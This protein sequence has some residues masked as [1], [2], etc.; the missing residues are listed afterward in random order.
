MGPRHFPKLAVLLLASVAACAGAETRPSVV[1]A[2][3]RAKVASGSTNDGILSHF[4]SDAFQGLTQDQLSE[5]LR[6]Y[7]EWIED[8]N[9]LVERVEG[10]EGCVVFPKPYR[11]EASG[12]WWELTQFA[13]SKVDGRWLVTRVNHGISAHW[14]ASPSG[15]LCWRLGWPWG[16]AHV[17]PN[18]S[19]ERTREG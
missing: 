19:L 3:I 10:N 1:V 9:R 16:A 18:T 14:N 2:G 17:S 5:L 12:E 13:L 6:L 8:P 4:S 15:D 11:A 7:A